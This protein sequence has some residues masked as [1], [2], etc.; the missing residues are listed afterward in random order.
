MLSSLPAAGSVRFSTMRFFEHK[1]PR[2]WKAIE[3]FFQVDE[4][5]VHHPISGIGIQSG[6]VR[7][8]LERD[9]ARLVSGA[10]DFKA[11]QP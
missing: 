4:A 5:T 9:A 11:T 8:S 6:L 2:L 1:Q 7:W 3:H 10:S